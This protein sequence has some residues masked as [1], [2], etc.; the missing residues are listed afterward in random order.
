MKTTTKP[1]TSTKAKV[2]ST[3]VKALEKKSTKK[4]EVIKE[5]TPINHKN[6]IETVIS[7]REVKYIYPPD[8]IDTL[9]RKSWRQKVRNKLDQL[10]RDMLR[11]KDQESKEFKKAKK[12]YKEYMATIMKVD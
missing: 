3:A 9:S 1:V 7:N 5:V 8:V 2:S 10:E 4:A 6:L 12:A 11:I